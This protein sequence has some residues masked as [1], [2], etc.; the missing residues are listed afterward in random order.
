MGDA[1]RLTKNNRL[2]IAIV[3]DVDAANERDQLAALGALM[4]LF[5]VYRLSD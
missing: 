2:G 1:H 4:C 3:I 5:G